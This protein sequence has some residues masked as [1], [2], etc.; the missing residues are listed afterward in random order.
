M[1]AEGR[2]Q[3]KQDGIR[4][5]IIAGN[6]LLRETLARTLRQRA[7]V[8]VLGSSDRAFDRA[9]APRPQ[10]VLIGAAPSVP[11]CLETIRRIRQLVP[12]AHLLLFGMEEN[13]DLFFQ[14]VRA[15][16]AGYLLGEASAGELVEAVRAVVRDEAVCP[17]RLCRALFRWFA[18]QAV[19]PSPQLCRR[20]GL[21][22][23]EQQLLPLLARGLTN[24]EIAA[25]LCLA[26]QTVKNHVH[27]ILRKLGSSSRL[28][29]LERLDGAGW[30]L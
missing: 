9:P 12:E 15:G 26:E 27:R 10:V 4:V 25:E 17:P 6:R 13:L 11:D 8:E 19:L 5:Y 7:H 28:E 20:H 24:K 30:R 22:R 3:E 14:A 18:T 2:L 16:I 21:T 23:R 1:S 29:A